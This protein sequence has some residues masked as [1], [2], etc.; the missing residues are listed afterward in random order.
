[1]KSDE[2]KILDKVERAR[3]AYLEKNYQES[4]ELYKW[5][6]EQIQ[7]D[8]VNLPIIWI[9]LGWS[10]YNFGDFRNCIAYLDKALTSELLT[11]RQQFD[12]LR[13]IGFSYGALKDSKNALRYL[14]KAMKK[15]L[16]ESEK[17]YVQFE[18]GKIHFLTGAFKKSKTYLDAAARFFSW[19]ESDYYQAIRYYQGFIALYEKQHDYAESSFTEIIKKAAG[20]K[21]KATGYFGMAHLFHERKDYNGLIDACKKVLELDQEFYDPETLAFFFCRAFMELNR[22]DELASFYNELRNK[23]PGGRY[24]SHYP[25]F[26]NVLAKGKENDGKS[27]N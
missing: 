25:M 3:K 13:L 11:A 22:P 18:V 14:E 21:N 20:N 9:E 6:E 15:K 27:G 16:P 26:E 5:V 12:C 7:D 19:K 4:V 2:Q 24:R 17:K 8:P 10:Y 1:M 23:Y